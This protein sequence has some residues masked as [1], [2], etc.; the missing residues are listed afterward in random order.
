MKSGHFERNITVG[1]GFIRERKNTFPSL[2]DRAVFISS[3]LCHFFVGD[4]RGHLKEPG[5]IILSDVM[6][7]FMC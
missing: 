2:F 4:H 6:R 3:F 5:F 7:V 1:D